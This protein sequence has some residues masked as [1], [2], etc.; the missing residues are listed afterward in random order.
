MDKIRF[1]T[2]RRMYDYAKSIVLFTKKIDKNYSSQV[3]AN[4]L[5]RSGTSVA[6]NVLE[7]R[8]ASSKKDFAKFFHYALKSANESKFWLALLRDTN[9]Q[10]EDEAKK[11]LQETIEISKIIA[12]SLLTVKNKS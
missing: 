8:G 3:I 11:L 5:L 9:S 12:T 6:A 10:V 2:Q 4:Q 1:E 7:A